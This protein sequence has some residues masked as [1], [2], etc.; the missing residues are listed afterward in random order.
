MVVIFEV[1]HPKITKQFTNCNTAAELRTALTTIY[2]SHSETQQFAATTKFYKFKY[3]VGTKIRDYI[4]KKT[5]LAATCRN[6][7]VE[8]SNSLLVATILVG[9][10]AEFKPVVLSFES[11]PAAERNL[12][13]LIAFLT[14]NE[15]FDERSK[16]A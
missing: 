12:N 11:K 14:R 5:D 9:L 2:E 3:E 16:A 10:P 1:V 6:A 15:M 7:G 13:E 4:L 8:I